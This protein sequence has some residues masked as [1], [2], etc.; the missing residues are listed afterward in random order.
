M[1]VC[2][3]LSLR[4]ST[5]PGSLSPDPPNS[6]NAPPEIPVGRSCVAVSPPTAVPAVCYQTNTPTRFIPGR[7]YF[8]AADNYP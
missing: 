1:G 3:R 2:L 5:R 6:R 8:A 7:H 4:L